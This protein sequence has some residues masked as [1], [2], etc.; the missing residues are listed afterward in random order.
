MSG[1][2]VGVAITGQNEQLNKILGQ[3]EQLLQSF[4]RKITGAS[5]DFTRQIKNTFTQSEGLF[6]S[7]GQRVASAANTINQS[8]GHSQT[9][10][11]NNN[12][13]LKDE[14]A[15]SEKMFGMFGK[16]VTGSITAISSTITAMV[17]TAQ[18]AFNVLKGGF[19]LVIGTA[20]AAWDLAEV[21]ARGTEEA[22]KLESVIAS[23]G[24]VA[25]YTQ[26]QLTGLADSLELVTKFESEATQAGMSTLLTFKNIRGDEFIR[27]TKLMLDMATV[28]KTDASGA[29]TLLGK[30]LND[31]LRGLSALQKGTAQFTKEQED[32]ILKLVEGGDVIGA[33]TLIMDVLAATYEGAAERVGKSASGQLEIIKNK[34]GNVW[35]AIG[36]GAFAVIEE[37][38]GEMDVL[39]DK[40]DS[41]Q[42]KFESMGHSFG[43]N[44]KS[45]SQ[46]L[47]ENF[48]DNLLYIS[49]IEAGLEAELLNLPTVFAIVA[50]SGV[51]MLASIAG[52]MEHTLMNVL[53][54]LMMQ[55]GENAIQFMQG[56]QMSGLKMPERKT[57]D[58]E[59]A[60]SDW[61]DTSLNSLA[62]EAQKIHDG[63]KLML[64]L[65]LNVFEGGPNKK[66]ERDLTGKGT[67]STTYPY[68]GPD[69]KPADQHPVV[70]ELRDLKAK[71]V[72][73]DERQKKQQEAGG[74]GD[75][76]A[77]GGIESLEEMNKRIQSAALNGPENKQVQLLEGVNQKL[78]IMIDGKGAK[79]QGIG[80]NGFNK[81]AG[82]GNIVGRLPNGEPIVQGNVNDFDDEFLGRKE[83]PDAQFMDPRRRKMFKQPF[84]KGSKQA[85]QDAAERALN[86]VPSP[87]HQESADEK[88][89]REQQ[90]YD[91]RQEE[92]RN[93]VVKGEKLTD[94]E[95]FELDTGGMAAEARRQELHMKQRSRGLSPDEQDELA[96]F[97][98]RGPGANSR[99]QGP[100]DA[101]GF[102]PPPGM[103]DQLPFGPQPD[104]GHDLQLPVLPDPFANDPFAELNDQI[105][106]AAGKM[107]NPDGERQ[108]D[109]LA[110]TKITNELLRGLQK[111]TAEGAD[112]NKTT[113]KKV[114]HVGRLY[115]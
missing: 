12:D 70:N 76:S 35:E 5:T 50:K 31:P 84:F 79:V 24:K 53:P 59:Q 80:V 100:A 67:P 92:L 22:A 63:N 17:T 37:F 27:A 110:E 45:M 15:K 106:Q 82:P 66:R 18:F 97:Q 44:L 96:S 71:F 81:N 95:M 46:E 87:P 74:H 40:T 51:Y 14:F 85:A 16:N 89:K 7:F 52:E 21:Y 3:S 54:A 72:K 83:H 88:L 8:I 68:L 108:A 38:G 62:A 41:L 1:N 90:A 61:L 107:L 55:A 114:D 113:A 20:K 13:K 91:I 65:G 9:G 36:A 77:R 42:D 98:N 109:I 75:A 64:D 102:A 78:G 112:A 26:Q 56:S 28:M 104:A 69:P 111:P 32:M 30:A 115:H 93:K 39:F 25:G 49:K 29:A 33:Q 57:Y 47:R 48:R 34:W 6:T 101:H 43:S 2:N 23:T 86:E 73:Q 4:G 94:D 58:Y 103:M 10:V 99:P 105:N 60:A 11:H 19:D